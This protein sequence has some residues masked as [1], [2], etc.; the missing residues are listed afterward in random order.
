VNVTGSEGGSLTGYNQDGNGSHYLGYAY[1]A[2]SSTASVT[3]TT[4]VYNSSYHFYGFTN[5]V[6]A[7]P[8]AR[9]APTA[10]VAPSGLS[11][12][13]V[14]SG[15]INLT[16]TDNSSNET[17]FKIERATNS[18]FT[19]SLTQVATTLAGVTNFSNTGLT[20]STP[21]FY[22][23][24]ATNTAGDS[25]NSAS[26]NATTRAGVAAPTYQAAGSAVSG[27]GAITAAWPAHQTGDIALLIV[28]SANQ[29]IS[30]SIPAGFVQVT[31]SPQGTGTAGG[32]AATRLA[33]YWKRATSSAESNPT[34]A[35]S[36]D[37]QI[38]RIITFRG[39]IES[40]N[41]WDV[42]V[43]TVASS[44]STSVSIPGATTTVA[45]TLVVAI[46]ANATDTA[47]ARTSAWTNSNLT[48]LTE[49]VDNNTSSGNGGGFGV[50]TGV[51]A[52]AGAYGATTATLATSSVQ[53]RVSLALKPA[54][55]ALPTGW[56]DS[57]IGSPSIAG[58][59]TY[60]G[61]VYTV[62]G[63]GADIWGTSDQ[64]NYASQGVTGNQTMEGRIT[65]LDN[66][67]PWAKS[68]IMFRDS[69]AAN[70]MYVDVLISASNGL[71]FQYR[72]STGGTTGSVGVALAAPTTA[73]PIWLKMVKVGTSYSAYYA[74]GTAY[75]ST[76]TQVGTAQTVSFSNTTFRAGLAVCSHDITELNVS[77]FDNVLIS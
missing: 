47:S 19:Q 20:A 49:R 46:V 51:M 54:T 64:F 56:S 35:D 24:R 17:G 9:V 43:G 36:G 48:S 55:G 5:Q 11:A 15:R 30:L 31:N 62:S 60:S 73:A 41:P 3:F 33:L 27:I 26:A 25:A 76:W 57:D 16:W 67:D 10:P 52:T 6:V 61:G 1:T 21:Y 14:S 23:V 63:S 53:G 39:V 71:V 65:S 7:I 66:T 13:T 45:N 8:T 69:T 38:A 58:S 2:S 37:H 4:T 22:R 74:T 75:P 77:I 72:N 50:A 70:S 29:A 34:V 28:E 32:A 18:T 44:A 42:S 40:G 59:A 68:G 12:T